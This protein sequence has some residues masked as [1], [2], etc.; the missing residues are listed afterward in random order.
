MLNTMEYF[1]NVRRV[2]VIRLRMCLTAEKLIAQTMQTYR[3][4]LLQIFNR[5]LH[6]TVK[7]RKTIIQSLAD[8]IHQ[9]FPWK[10]SLNLYSFQLWMD[11]TCLQDRFIE[12]LQ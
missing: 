8:Y 5:S 3:K 2:P 12:R 11:I 4:I 7:Y 10:L 1:L 9:V 6:R